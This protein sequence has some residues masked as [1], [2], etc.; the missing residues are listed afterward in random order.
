MDDQYDRFSRQVIIGMEGEVER[1]SIQL[2]REFYEGTEIRPGHH[3]VVQHGDRHVKAKARSDDLLK[4]GEVRIGPRMADRLGLENGTLI[5]VEDKVTFTE[6]VFDELEDAV[7]AFEDRVEEA[8]D[9]VLVEGAERRAERREKALD[10][11]IPSRTEEPPPKAIEVEPDLSRIGEGPPEEPVM[12]ISDQVKV[13]T[14]DP[15]GDGVKEFRPG[16]DEEEEE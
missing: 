4:S 14:P 5:R 7:D 6:R 9:R 15:E 16:A 2:P 13:W 3:V 10:T 1:G 11:I 8:A 12:D